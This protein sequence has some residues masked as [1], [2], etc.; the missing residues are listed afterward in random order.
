[1]DHNH[2]QSI[3][4][5]LQSPCHRQLVKHEGE[6]LDDGHIEKVGAHKTYARLNGL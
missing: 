3:T 4:G 1:M 5:I 2:V 6:D